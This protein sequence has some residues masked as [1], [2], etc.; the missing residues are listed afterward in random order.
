MNNTNLFQLK[1]ILFLISMKWF[2]KYIVLKRIT[3]HFC[4]K[5]F[6]WYSIFCFLMKLN[7]LK[8]FEMFWN[9]GQ[10]RNKENSRVSII[11]NYIL[12]FFFIDDGPFFLLIKKKT[13]SRQFFARFL[14]LKQFSLNNNCFDL[15]VVYYRLHYRNFFTEL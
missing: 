9:V 10:K 3:V 12:I 7:F 4:C 2:D 15:F 11:L 1:I 6:N 13:A 8:C 5:I 14:T